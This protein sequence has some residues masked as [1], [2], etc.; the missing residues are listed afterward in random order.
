[1]SKKEAALPQVT[2]HV[3]EF[4]KVVPRRPWGQAEIIEFVK[5]FRDCSNISEVVQRTKLPLGTV[6]TKARQ[7]RKNGINLPNLT[8]GSKLDWD[9][10]VALLG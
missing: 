1:M 5:V 10:I 8:R 7:C 2:E 4:A 6:Y 3:P 9:S